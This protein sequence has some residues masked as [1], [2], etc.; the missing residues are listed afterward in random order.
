MPELPEVETTRRFIEPVLAGARLE[1]VAVRRPR[2]ARRNL[3]P[4]DVS[5]RL[6]GRRVLT[7]SRRGKFIISEVEGDLTWVI[8]LGMS[9]R[10]QIARPGE[11]EAPHTNAVF[12]T[13]GGV[14]LRFVDPRTFGFVAVF[15]PDELSDS[16]LDR[17]GRDAL[18]D[19]PTVDEIATAFEG[20]VPSVKSALLDQRFISGLGNIYADEVLHIARVHPART[21]GSL[22]RDEIGRIREAIVPVLES[23]V[24]HGG[25]SLNDLAY[26][27]PDGRAGE[28]LERLGVYGREGEP[29][30]T[31]G[32]PIERL[33]I[34][35]RSSHFCPTCQHLA[36]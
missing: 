34:A 30:R 25:T 23:G 10:L 32:T 4:E 12:A 18:E 7:V 33:V 27:L 11:V 22:E 36:D 21:I 15:T 17:I 16:G 20:R 14:E 6:T 29:C 1:R 24:A 3:R 31:C 19:L 35:Q 9:G 13:D 8:H 2:T 5:E 28:F 26:L